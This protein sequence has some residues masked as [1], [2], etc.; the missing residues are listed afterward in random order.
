VFFKPLW[1]HLLSLAVAG[2]AMVLVTAAT[3]PGSLP[4][5][6]QASAVIKIEGEADD[7]SLVAD[8]ATIT[9]VLSALSSRFNLK[10]TS[11]AGL[12]GTIAGTYS[13]RLQYVLERILDGY[14]Y[15]IIFSDDGLELKIWSH[16]APIAGPVTPPPLNVPAAGNQVPAPN[17]IAQSPQTNG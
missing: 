14:D 6:S 15:V 12:N 9:D 16:S 10:Y 2:R 8:D 5:A 4:I 11:I 17:P 7:L 1:H 3:V 13:G